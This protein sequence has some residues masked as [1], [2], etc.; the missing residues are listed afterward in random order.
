MCDCPF[1]CGGIHCCAA[2]KDGS[3]KCPDE[4]SPMDEARHDES[5]HL[6]QG[7][8]KNGSATE[9]ELAHYSALVH[10]R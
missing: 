2:L 3:G 4:V 7:F 9:A 5:L 6:W 1:P 8:I 10:G